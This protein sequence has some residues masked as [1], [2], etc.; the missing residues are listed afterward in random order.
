M[1]NSLRGRGAADNPHNRFERLR[2]VEDAE[3]AE[4][5][6]LCREDPESG[7]DPADRPGPDTRFY[8][9]P[10]RKVLATNQSPDLP[11]DASLNPY[12]G[13]EHGC[14][15]CYARPTHEY[16]GFSAGLDFES[17]IL[18]KQNAPG[19]LRKELS[20]RS[21]KPQT[22]AIGGVTDAYQPVERRLQITRRCLEVFAEFRNPFTIVT[23]SALVTRDIDVLERLV[24][25]NAV[26]VNVSVTTLDRELH[27]TMEPRS[28]TPARRLGA[29]EALARAGIPVSVMVAP[30]IPGINDSE[31]SAIVSAAA[32]AGAQ[33]A[34][35]IVLRLPHGVASLF[36]DWLQRHFPDR[37]QKVL[38]RVRDMRG[39]RLN[40]S[41]FHSRFR[42]TGLFNEQIQNLFQ[43]A[44]RRAG[45]DTTP[46]AL[47]AESFE[48]P[49]GTQ[50]PLFRAN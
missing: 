46:P 19:L 34:T 16:L 10:S 32:Q 44:C 35:R 39:G 14:I 20:S 36:S 12:R 9:D 41:R 22:V 23:K 24:P 48:R 8:A 1:N 50:L 38:N 3:F 49:G 2:S 37:A 27:R 29:I 31:I 30:I 21:W 5:K 33:S 11:F 6:R 4:Y 7:A 42:G 40:D 45:I 15:Y 17:R 13:C 47:S 18:V 43:L 28:S 26:R 25:F